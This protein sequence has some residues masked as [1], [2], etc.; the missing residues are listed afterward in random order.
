MTMKEIL[1]MEAGIKLDELVAEGVMKYKKPNFF[2]PNALDL[3]L[4]GDA[5][6]IPGWTCVCIDEEKDTPKWVPDLYSKDIS[7]A[8]QVVECL[9][10]QG[11][12]LEL[13]VIPGDERTAFYCNIFPSEIDGRS[14]QTGVILGDS[15]PEAICRAALLAKPERV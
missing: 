15:M 6:H 11:L 5:F 9:S 1:A 12:R 3:C 10:K 13:L 2:P 4:A 14:R 8:W 7:A